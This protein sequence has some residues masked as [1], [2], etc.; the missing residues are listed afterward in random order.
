MAPRR[1]AGQLL[2]AAPGLVDPNFART[3]VLVLHHDEQ[4]GLGLV[5]NRPTGMPVSEPLPQWVDLAAEPPVV[6]VGGPV[7]PGS[8]ICL[9]LREPGSGPD[10]RQPSLEPWRPVL[11]DRLGTLDLNAD[12]DQAGSGLSALRVFAGYAGWG[13]GQLDSEVERGGWLVVGAEESDAMTGQ[14]ADLWKTV[15]R[16]QGGELA[17]LAAYP[18]DLSAN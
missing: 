10:P 15:L 7:S 9:A 3:V 6:F 12:R 8:A 16:R 13:P 11:G 4:G 5:L 18:M 14:P 17:I 1:L 2:V